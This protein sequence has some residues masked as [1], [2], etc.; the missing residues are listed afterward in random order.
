MLLGQVPDVF[1]TFEV[2]DSIDNVFFDGL[3]YYELVTMALV[4][5]LDLLGVK[6]HIMVHCMGL[7]EERTR[8]CL[9]Y[10][11]AKRIL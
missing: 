3:D 5:I 2:V 4:G 10:I 1:L 8:S 11:V 7:I 9:G 6:G